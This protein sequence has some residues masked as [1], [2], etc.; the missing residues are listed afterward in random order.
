MGE[1]EQIAATVAKL[2]RIQDAARK[3]GREV[4]GEKQGERK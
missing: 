1:K 4:Q 2:K 3:I